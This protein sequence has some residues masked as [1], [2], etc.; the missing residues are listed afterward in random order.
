REGR[1]WE[2]YAWLKARTVAGD[3]AAGE[4]WLET[5]R[6]FVYRR[7]LDFTALDGLRA[8]KAAI[9]AEMQRRDMADDL[10][11]GRGGIRE[12][13][14]LVQSLQL[15]RGG[16]EPALRG[17]QLLPALQALVGGGQIAS[18]DGDALAEADRFLRRPENRV[19]MLADA[20]VHS[21]PEDEEG[22]ERIAVALGYEGWAPL[23]AT[24]ATCRARVSAEFDALLV[25]RRGQSA[26]D[27]LEGYWRLLP[28]AGEATVLA[29]A[30]FN[31]AGGADA[32][33]RDF[34]RS[35]GVRALSDAA[36]G[37]LDRV[38]PALLG[39]AARSAQPDAALRRLLGLLQSILRRASYLALLD[40]QPSALGRLVDVLARSALL[41]ER[42]AAYPLLL[43]ELLDVRVAGPIP[44]AAEMHQACAAAVDSG[45]GDPEAAL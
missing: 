44:D 41:A 12:I 18:E 26:P 37:R 20:Q 31:D 7:Y 45:D 35:N 1:D 23:A 30:G 38:V 25:P 28:Q 4:A 42:I 5:L 43:D 17:R 2:R 40:E 16:R 9:V 33:V 39:A 34:A 29:D 8:M 32:A 22:R 6:P 13:E 21:L 14:F 27:A 15:I 24:L 36:R 19:Q 3:I 11:R 10:K